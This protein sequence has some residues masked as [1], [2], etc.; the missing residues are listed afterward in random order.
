M[1]L[2]PNLIVQKSPDQMVGAFDFIKKSTT[3]SRQS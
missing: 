1:R 2:K 3:K